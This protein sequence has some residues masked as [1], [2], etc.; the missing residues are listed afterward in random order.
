MQELRKAET[1]E[2]QGTLVALINC[3]VTSPESVKERMKLRN[4]F[5]GV[6]VCVCVC[7]CVLKFVKYYLLKDEENCHLGTFT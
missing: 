3:I 7:V 5:I 1:E 6:C 2:Y 4:E